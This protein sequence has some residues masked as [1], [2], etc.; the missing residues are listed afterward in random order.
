MNSNHDQH[1]APSNPL[2]D[3][4]SDGLPGVADDD[5]AS[6]YDEVDTG[7]EADGDL[8]GRAA[9]QPGRPRRTTRRWPSGWPR[10]SRR[11]PPTATG[12]EPGR[13]VGRLVDPEDGGYDDDEPDA[14]AWD[15]GAAGGGASAEE[16]AIHEVV[17][18]DEDDEE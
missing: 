15:A 11:S 16:L 17:D 4:E 10:R 13:P 6:A 3:P 8:L 12:S 5:S 9:R 18:E 7:R 14:I 2:S 1:G